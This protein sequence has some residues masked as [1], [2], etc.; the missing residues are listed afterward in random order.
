M[1]A[2][3][4]LCLS[5]SGGASLGAYQAGATAALL[6]ALS[7]LREEHQVDVRLDAVGGASAGAIVGMMAAH[8]VLEGTDGCEV[9]F[10]A[11]VEGVSIDTLLRRRSRGPL[12]LEGV[13]ARLPELLG[14][15]R[16]SGSGQHH[17]LVL[18]VSL[19]ALRGHTYEIPGLRREEPVVGVTYSDSRDFRLEP[20]GGLRALLE[21]EGASPLE[22]VLASASH[23]GAFAPR[24]ME[25]LWYTDGGLIQPKPLGRALAAARQVDDGDQ[26]AARLTLMVHPRSKDPSDAEEWSDA[27]YDATWAG[28]L[29]RGLAIVS[30]QPLYDDLERVERDNFRLAWTEQLVDRLAPHLSDSAGDGLRELLGRIEDDKR[31]LEGDSD[32]ARVSKPG[33]AAGVDELVRSAIC[34]IGGLTG[35]RREAI[36]LISPL[37]LT[38]DDDDQGVTSLLAGELMGD[39]GGFLDRELR[40]SDFAL[41]Y[42]ST[43]A[44][45]RRGLGE[46]GVADDA[47]SGAVEAIEASRPVS[48][49]DARRGHAKERDLPWRARVRLALFLLRAVR[50]LLR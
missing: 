49:E 36:D 9:M 2:D 42:E 44:W 22:A 19:T 25:G 14:Q 46:C 17:P 40:Q 7:H 3:L 12:S 48:L 5:L 28:G 21:P 33:P 4:R 23:P 47:V 41:G 32:A 16:R 39:F 18:H 35:K 8:S 6:V 38:E 13:R 27:S 43:L 24:V 50:A 34:E 37:L 30:E 10:E 26:A 29:S 1:P 11:W 31:S 20:G 15:A 45:A